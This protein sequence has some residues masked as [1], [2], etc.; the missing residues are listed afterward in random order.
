MFIPFLPSGWIR[1]CAA[2][3]D[4]AF[5]H[6]LR[7][8]QQKLWALLQIYN[9]AIALLFTWRERQMHSSRFRLFLIVATNCNMLS[10]YLMQS[11]RIKKLKL[12]GQCWEYCSYL[13]S[14][15]W[16]CAADQNTW[17][18]LSFNSRVILIFLQ[19]VAENMISVT[20]CTPVKHHFIYVLSIISSSDHLGAPFTHNYE[21]LLHTL[22]HALKINGL[23]FLRT[24]HVGFSLK[25]THCPVFCFQSRQTG[26]R[27]G[28]AVTGRWGASFL[29][30]LTSG[31]K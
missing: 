6:L 21:R 1:D 3:G 27:R 24:V 11:F 31:S 19:A 2:S 8:F 26:N 13:W 23:I 22:C 28:G 29:V 10:L 14:F 4:D 9:I 7:H 5:R 18:C 17:T 12:R 16:A 25:L 20:L 15:D 30:I